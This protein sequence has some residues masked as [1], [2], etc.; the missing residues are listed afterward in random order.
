MIPILQI[1]PLSIQFP[2]LIF[3]L[4]ISVSFTILEQLH[5][6]KKIDFSTPNNIIF[7][8][9]ISALI[10]ARLFYVLAYPSLFIKSPVSIISPH[11]SLLDPWGAL[12]AAILMYLVLARLRSFHPLKYLDTIALFLS[13]LSIFI[14]LSNFTAGGY[15]GQPTR[16]P[17]GINY[18]GE[19]RHPVQL[20]EALGFLFISL[21]LSY[22]F[23]YHKHDATGRLMLNFLLYGTMLKFI[24]LG[25]VTN[26]PI[27]QY[28]LRLE[29]FLYFVMSIIVFYTNIHFSNTKARSNG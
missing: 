8:L 4:G 11:P 5:R 1:G 23:L 3:L 2:P 29:Q 14:S 22:K 12:T 27:L 19:T 10:G 21:L 15:L 17:W 7:V 9:L 18:L 26:Q 13:Y 24:V 6:R 28:G 16:L 20:Y 25:L